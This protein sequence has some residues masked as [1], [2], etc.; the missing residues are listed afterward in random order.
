MQFNVA[1]QLKQPVGSTRGYEIDYSPREDEDSHPVS[2]KVELTRTNQGILVRG[3][4]STKT[5]LVCSRC[6]TT[7]DYPIT[8]GIEEEYLPSV[9]IETGVLL[10]TP[11]DSQG[12]TI[13]R[14]HILDLTEAVRQYVLLNTP[15]NPL[16]RPDCAGLC[17]Q[18]GADLNQ[19]PCSCMSRTS[20]NAKSGR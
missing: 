14:H 7:F 6:L 13:D 19:G 2:G 3:N 5:S 18:C 9:D 20:A 10:P 15:M 11:E 1:Q 17:P 4:L 8:I 16:C 12:F